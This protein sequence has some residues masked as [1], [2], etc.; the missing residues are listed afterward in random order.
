VFQTLFRDPV[1]F[2]LTIIPLTRREAA[3]KEKLQKGTPE[4]G[5]PFF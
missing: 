2:A 4:G 5:V 1:F 3:T